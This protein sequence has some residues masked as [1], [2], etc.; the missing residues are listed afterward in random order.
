MRTR[1]HLLAVALAIPSALAS[2]QAPSRVADD[3]AF[4]GVRVLKTANAG[5]L[6]W[7]AELPTDCAKCRLEL[8][9]FTTSQNPK[10]FFFHFWAPATEQQIPVHIKVDPAKVRGVLVG[11]TDLNLSKELSSDDM[12][13]RFT[14]GT[15]AISFRTTAD[16]ITFDVPLQPHGLKLP[17]DDAGDVTDAYTYIETPGVYVRI[18]HNDEQRRG[19]AYAIEPWPAVETKAATNLAFATREA[20]RNLDLVPAL[21]K[22]GVETVTIMN[23]DTNYPTQGP[24]TAHD[25]WF[26]HWH[27]H[28]YWSTNP[29]IRKVGHFMLKPDGL[30]DINTLSILQPPPQYPYVGRGEAD[31]TETPNGDV[32]YSQTITPEGYF[33]LTAPNGAA[34]RFTPLAKG[35]DSGVSLA[36]DK[37]TPKLRVRAEDNLETGV[38]RVF[39]D[40]RLRNEYQYDP[41]TAAL[42]TT[43]NLP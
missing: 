42:K 37:G 26:P 36:C 3:S 30:M 16:G 8:N 14:E 31:E 7:T 10:D 19:G 43:K 1:A 4:L 29:R 27:M 34:C 15:A 17:P 28:L 12:G 41:D 13:K 9:K 11:R 38:L 39:L 35:F 40:D 33:V 2:A 21:Q 5:E 6:K 23:F 18:S 20:I 25:D 24:F 32:L 22:A